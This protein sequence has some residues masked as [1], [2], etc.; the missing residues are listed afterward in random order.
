[1]AIVGHF[2]DLAEASKLV[3]DKLLL[4]GI[5][6][7]IIEEGQLLPRLPVTVIDSKSIIYNREKTLPSADFYDIHEQIP[8]K[9][10][11]EYSSQ[12]EVSLKRIVRQDVLDKFIMMTYKNPNDYKAVVISELRKG[13]MRT[14]EDKLIYGDSSVNPKEFDGLGKLCDPSMKIAMNGALSLS[15]L[16]ELIDKVRPKPDFLLMPFEL[17][18]RFDAAMWEA[19]I[20]QGSIVRVATSPN[21]LGERVTHFE[22]IPILPSDYMVAED[23]T[24]AKWSSGTKYYSI[25]AVRLGHIQSGGVCLVVGGDTGGPD[26]FHIVEL[27]E[28]E[29]FDAG[30]IRLVAYCALAVGSTKALGRIYAITDAALTA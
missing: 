19:G 22:G 25:F 13:C 26:F 5:I 27:D 24:G 12:V 10:D 18:R 7:E 8:W 21:G 9:A 2:K 1:M 11:V 16:R 23:A 30:G 20:S 29:D 14:I 6:E 28:L 3:Q 17:Q 4:A 15:K